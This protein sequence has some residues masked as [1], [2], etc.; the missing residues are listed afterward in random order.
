MGYHPYC[1]W[2]AA[3]R[4]TSQTSTGALTT[5]ESIAWEWSAGCD[6]ARARDEQP[7]QLS[8]STISCS[9]RFPRWTTSSG[10]CPTLPPIGIAA[11]RVR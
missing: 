8:S 4:P 10:A 5:S 6:H 1:I 2:R 9:S 3:F 11:D 7:A